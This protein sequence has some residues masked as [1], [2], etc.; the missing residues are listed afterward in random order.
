MGSRLGCRTR[1]ELST[2][3]TA[4]NPA[5]MPIDSVVPCVTPSP[6]PCVRP[7]NSATSAL[8]VV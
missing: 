3:A 6:P 5:A 8:P 2:I 1:S 7:N 4:A